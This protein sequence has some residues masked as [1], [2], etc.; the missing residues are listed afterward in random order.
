MTFGQIKSI[1]EKNLLESYSNSTSFKKTLK[2]FKHNVLNN[3][4]FSK[5]YSLYDELSTPKGLNESDAKE[6][7]EEGL[8]LIRSILENTQLPKSGEI[9]ENNYKDLD[10][11]VYTNNINISERIESKKNVLKVLKST[12]KVAES[13]VS[14]PLKSMVS[15]A[16]Q[17]VQKYLES[18]DENIKKEVFHVLASKNE[19][20]ESEYVALKE[21]TVNKLKSLLDQNSEIE[22]K[23]KISETIDKIKVESFDQVNYVRL[24]HLD[25]SIQIPS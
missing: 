8:S 10:N 2:E 3:K 22:I 17:T 23:N 18:L 1:L 4:N 9:S 25:E 21:N 7:L 15:I 20:L 19:D 5:L 24:K 14:I 16:N 13:T 11:L 6:Y 12:P